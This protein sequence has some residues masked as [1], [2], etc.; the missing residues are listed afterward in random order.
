MAKKVFRQDNYL[1]IK[2]T[3]SGEVEFSKYAVNIMIEPDI[4]D[5]D[6][7]RFFFFKSY[8]E[9]GDRV[10]FFF[11]D[12]SNL[13]DLGGTPYT[14][15]TF[16]SFYT[17]ETGS[18]FTLLNVTWGNIIGTLS[19]QT[20]LQSELD[21]KRDKI[22]P[23]IE[24]QV[25]VTTTPYAVLSTDY[26]IRVEATIA[27]ARVDLPASASNSGRILVVKKIDA[28]ANTVTLD[29]NASETIDG[30]T[31]QVLTTQFES[32]KIQSD[33]INWIIIGKYL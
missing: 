10:Q 27:N 5:P 19:D 18:G 23:T 11:D 12:I 4:V 2:D 31:T 20:D 28:T 32:M 24:A 22:G 29:G 17:K 15:V 8:A 6:I 3:V 16:V 25:L 9:I 13:E 26:T 14:K 33:G 1:I 21:A 7:F 30:V